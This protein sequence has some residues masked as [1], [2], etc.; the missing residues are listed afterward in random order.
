MFTMDKLALFLLPLWFISIIIVS[1][2]DSFGSTGFGDFRNIFQDSGLS[3]QRASSNNLYRIQSRAGGGI[4]SH[5]NSHGHGNG[6]SN[7]NVHGHGN[8]I[9][10]GSGNSHGNGNGRGNGGSPTRKRFT[11]RD[12]KQKQDDLSCSLSQSMK[13]HAKKTKHEN[14]A[15]NHMMKAKK[16]G[17]KATEERHRKKAHEHVKKAVKHA[18]NSYIH[19]EMAK[20]HAQVI[21]E[22]AAYLKK[23][24]YKTTSPNNTKQPT[25]TKKPVYH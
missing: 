8:S 19:K 18:I 11:H 15:I 22:E 13:E 5:G 1:K 6:I 16:A 17:D 10:N 14:K 4:S 25:T 9:G 2:V 23:S 21:R 7:G 12:F 24:P 20:G 3:K